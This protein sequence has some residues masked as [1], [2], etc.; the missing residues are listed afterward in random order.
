MLAVRTKVIRFKTSCYFSKSIIWVRQRYQRPT[1]DIKPT[2]TYVRVYFVNAMCSCYAL[3]V[4]AKKIRNVD[5]K[6]VYEP[7]PLSFLLVI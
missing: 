1:M 7:F 4:F 6:T 5:Q 3:N 2:F